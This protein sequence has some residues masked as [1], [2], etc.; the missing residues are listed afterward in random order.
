MATHISRRT[1]LAAGAG[2]VAGLSLPGVAAASA[3]GGPAEHVALARRRPR[4]R[5]AHP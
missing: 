1:V 2:T 5:T 4:L 3:G